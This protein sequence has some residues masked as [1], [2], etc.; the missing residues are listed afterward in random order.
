[1]YDEQ[2]QV[3]SLPDVAVAVSRAPPEIGSNDHGSV[4]LPDVLNQISPQVTNDFSSET[5]EI[6]NLIMQQ[7]MQAAQGP[8]NDTQGSAGNILHT[9]GGPALDFFLSEAIFKQQTASLSASGKSDAQ[10]MQSVQGVASSQDTPTTAH[11]I[12][13]IQ[14][15]IGIPA[16]HVRQ[17]SEDSA[18]LNEVVGSLTSDSMAVQQQWVMEGNLPTEK[19]HAII[20]P[21]VDPT[22]EAATK[23]TSFPVPLFPVDDSNASVMERSRQVNM[24]TGT[25]RYM[26][27]FDQNQFAVKEELVT[28]G[29][30]IETGYGSCG[31]SSNA[32]GKGTGLPEGL[33]IYDDK[34]QEKKKLRAER[35]RQSAAASRERKKH[36]VKELER[37]ASIHSKENAQLQVGQ[38]EGFKRRLNADKELVEENN[39][40]KKKLFMQD[41]TIQSLTQ[42]LDE[43][44][45]SDN[46]PILKRP[47]TW[48][49]ERWGRRKCCL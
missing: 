7:R 16:Q 25:S 46:K 34:T 31:A 33:D 32:E 1:M 23:Q 15:Q 5:P 24:A 29:G 9:R 12:A 43:S 19:G 20:S 14:G 27:E 6:M 21:P 45:I 40:L 35:N 39:T 8:I 36:H 10:K 2:A 28:A 4:A 41:L 49:G 22:A 26:A 44:G 37:R 30:A 48:S 11:G 3:Q 18:S 13:R 42:K 47:N 17:V 38:I